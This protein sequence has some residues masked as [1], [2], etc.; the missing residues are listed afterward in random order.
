LQKWPLQKAQSPEMR[1]AAALQSLK[2]H[3]IFLGGMAAVVCGV[4]L[5]EVTSRYGCVKW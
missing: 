5:G 1:W 4:L 3:L 2:L